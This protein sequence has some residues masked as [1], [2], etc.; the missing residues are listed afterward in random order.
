M[1][2]QF[3]Q[4]LLGKSKGGVHVVVLLGGLV[5]WGGWFF[6]GGGGGGGGRVRLLFVKN[7]VKFFFGF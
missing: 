5:F 7:N 2:P 4:I 6:F 1:S 3:L